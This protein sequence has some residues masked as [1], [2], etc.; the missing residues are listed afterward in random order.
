MAVMCVRT[1]I[2][3]R[4]VGH[5]SMMRMMSRPARRTIRAGVRRRVQRNR[6]G[7]ALIVASIAPVGGSTPSPHARLLSDRFGQDDEV[8]SS[9]YGSLVTGLWTGSESNRIAGQI[10]QL[11][12]WRAYAGAGW[13]RAWARDVVAVLE[14]SKQN[15]LRREAEEQF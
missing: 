5:P 7:S 6:F 4:V 1:L 3:S 13:G 12:A 8:K 14:Q 11:N 10:E 15:A 9:F 2:R